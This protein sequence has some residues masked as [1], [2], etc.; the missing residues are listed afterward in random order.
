[1]MS[2]FHSHKVIV[3]GITFDSKKE[4]RRFCELSAL[5]KAGKIQNLER[6]VKFTLIPTQREPDTIG[7]RGGVK[8]GKLLERELAYFADFMY[9]EDGKWIVEDVKGLRTTDY[10]I[11]RKLM[12]YIHKIRIREV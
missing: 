8:V 9:M 5:E 2:K 6:Q 10:I 1:M 12:L 3:D 11:K 4:Y 7:S